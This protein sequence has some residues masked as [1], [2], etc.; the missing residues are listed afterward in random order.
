MAR[1]VC[2]F[3]RTLE[4]RLEHMSLVLQRFKEEGLKLR[5]KC[6]FGLREM[7]YFG[8]TISVIRI[9]VSK[10]FEAVADS[11]VPTTE[12]KVHS[13][14]QF[15]NFYAI[16]IRH[17][18]D[19]MAPLTNSLRKSMRHNLTLPLACLEAFE[20]L[21]LRLISVPCM[22]V[23]VVSSDATFTVATNASKEG[24]GRISL[25]EQGGGLQ[26]VSYWARKLNPTVSAATPTL[27]TI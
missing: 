5:L 6:F 16:F 18:S 7:E 1:F 25:E 27:C 17:F 21:K 2:V 9:S 24:I 12:N 3:S 19:F 26:P 14:V 15:Y 8:Y 11:Q 22:I 4:E 13:F 23:P 10:K 20:T